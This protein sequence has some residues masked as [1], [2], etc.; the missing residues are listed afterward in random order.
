M[1]SQIPTP[2]GDPTQTDPLAQ[3]RD[4]QF[5]APIDSW[6][7]AIGWWLLGALAFIG[8]VY[9][10]YTVYRLWQKNAYRRE[11]LIE[12]EH[13][14]SQFS[15]DKT[16]YLIGCNQLLKRVALTHFARNEVAPLSGENWVSFLDKTADTKEFSM[17]EGQALIHGQYASEISYNLE[18]LHD[19]SKHW[20][21]KHRAVQHVSGADAV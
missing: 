16:G 3:L 13:L 6:P 2:S 5:P 11:A 9:G 8:I 14:R 19:I 17:G 15:A 18:L 10:I 21:A 12:L 4:I 7:P 1:A 20:I